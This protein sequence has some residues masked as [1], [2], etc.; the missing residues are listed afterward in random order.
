MDRNHGLYGDAKADAALQRSGVFEHL[1]RRAPMYDRDQ[2][3]VQYR[4]PKDR[5]T[6]GA[7][8]WCRSGGWHRG[9]T[10]IAQRGG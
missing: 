1:G 3:A 10:L 8:T 4:V 7:L 5:G 2:E 6:A 9:V